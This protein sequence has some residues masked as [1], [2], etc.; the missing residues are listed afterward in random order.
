MTR[1]IGEGVTVPDEPR[2]FNDVVEP[3]MRMRSRQGASVLITIAIETCVIATLVAIP[4]M[5]IEIVPVP[6]QMIGAFI[7]APAP[8]PPPAAPPSPPSPEPSRPE[9]A[10]VEPAVVEPGPTFVPTEA[11]VGVAPEVPVDNSF[12]RGAAGVPRGTGSPDGVPGGFGDVL[13]PPPLAPVPPP[14]DPVPVGGRIDPPRKVRDVAPV[15]P[16]VAVQSRTDGRV[17][18]E[19]TIGVDGRVTN[20]RVLQ[21]HPLLVDAAVT[22]VSQWEFTPTLLNGEPIPVLMSVTVWFRLR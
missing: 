16:V 7:A 12:E 11:P 20:T 9:P 22:A 2:L 15:Y 10:P 14:R 18:V 4:L 8:P 6:S 5:A 21:G 3:S 19:A 1:A 13:R 17:I